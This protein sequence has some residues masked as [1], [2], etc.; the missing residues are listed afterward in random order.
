MKKHLILGI[1]LGFLIASCS[2]P[3]KKNQLSKV[4]SLY[5]LL[6]SAST[7]LSRVNMDTV[8]Q[9]LQTYYDVNKK[10]SEHYQ[11]Y[12]NEENWAY[13]CSYQNVRKP[14]K[15]LVKNYI[16]YQAEVDSSKKQLE[17]LKHDIKKNLLKE[18]EFDGC[19]AIESQSINA[20]TF[21]IKKNIESVQHQLKNFDT[22]HPY[23]LRLIESYNSGKEK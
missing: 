21:K 23:M 8:N 9:R 4:D 5:A 2:N 10:V 14:F 13:V 17:N 12:R 20:L 19:F 1:T 3:V 6:D 16:K 22:I 15:T 7:L 11:E 18:N